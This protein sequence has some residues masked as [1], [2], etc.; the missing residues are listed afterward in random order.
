M[1]LRGSL[2]R[3]SCVNSQRRLNKRRHGRFLYAHTRTSTEGHLF[4]PRDW[5]YNC[6]NLPH[7]SPNVCIPKQNT[8]THQLVW[9]SEHIGQQF[10]FILFSI[11][12]FVLV[13]VWA[14][15]ASQICCKGP[16]TAEGRPPSPTQYVKTKSIYSGETTSMQ[17]STVLWNGYGDPRQRHTVLIGNQGNSLEGF[18]NL[19]F[20]GGC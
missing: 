15:Q 8:T 7:V 1:H 5:A 9:V 14:P 19:N 12:K 2:E 3:V 11:C 10:I 6:F 17:G 20:I 13:K 16:K 4:C 18:S